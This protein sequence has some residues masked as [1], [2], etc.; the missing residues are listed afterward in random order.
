MSDKSIKR[1]LLFW[2]ILAFV[3]AWTVLLFFFSPKEIVEM[4]GVNNSYLVIFLV[5]VIGAFS[6]FTTFSAYP[7]IVTMAAGKLDPL[8]IGVV[9]GIGLAIGDTFFY[10]FGV[11]AQMFYV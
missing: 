8:L 7:V 9:A 2:I 6:S 4:I 1:S 3:V 11:C 10:F 5:A